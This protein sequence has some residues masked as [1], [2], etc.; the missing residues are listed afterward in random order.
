MALIN[1]VTEDR[2]HESLKCCRGIAETKGYNEGFKETEFTF[3][4]GFS[5]IAL[6]DTNVVIAPADVHFDKIVSAL[7]FINKFWDQWEW[8]SVFDCDFV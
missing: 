5:F 3:K 7:K 6:F 1:K 4:G 2:V 8:C